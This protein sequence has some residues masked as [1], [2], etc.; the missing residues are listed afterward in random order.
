M[1]IYGFYH[2]C[3]INDW[4]DIVTKQLN[5]LT[6]SSLLSKTNSL[7]VSILGDKLQQNIFIDLIKDFD[8]IQIVISSPNI[9]LYEEPILNYLKY[10]SENEYFYCYYLHAKGVSITEENKTWYHNSQDLNHLK[11][12]INDWREFME[13]FQI[14]R[15]EDN[16]NLLDRFDTCGVNY[17]EEPSPHYSGNFW[18][19]KSDYIKTLNELPKLTSQNRW[20]AEF[21]IGTNKTG[22]FFNHKTLNA[23]YKEIINKKE[24]LINY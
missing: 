20:L 23:G 10:L 9:L 2:V 12:C 14:Y 5:S 7:F 15:F 6:E 22:K 8:N 1:K 19:T 16:V 17:C 21:W 24:Y 18:W 4:V 3:L 11:N 13:Y